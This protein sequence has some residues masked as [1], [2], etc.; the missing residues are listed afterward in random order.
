MY[1]V[2]IALACSLF[3]AEVANMVTKKATI[4]ASERTNK[5]TAIAE[6]L[7]WENINYLM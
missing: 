1:V 6:Y 5:P 7:M 4:D 3:K 2:A